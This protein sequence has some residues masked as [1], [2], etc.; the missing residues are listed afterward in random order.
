MQEASNVIETLQPK[1]IMGRKRSAKKPPRPSSCPAN[2][3]LQAD[4]QEVR[5]WKNATPAKTRLRVKKL[6]ERR[7]KQL[8]QERQPDGIS[9]EEDTPAQRLFTLEGASS[10]HGGQ[11][12]GNAMPGKY[13]LHGNAIS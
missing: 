1:P 7:K 13:N 3:P 6:R 4:L 12:D 9:S 2:P 8:E 5:T 10:P 11:S